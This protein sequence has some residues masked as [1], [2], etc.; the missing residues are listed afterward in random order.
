[1]SDCNPHLISKEYRNWIGPVRAAEYDEM[2]QRWEAN[3]QSNHLIREGLRVTFTTE[4]HWPLSGCAKVGTRGTIGYL[5]ERSCRVL[6]LWSGRKFYGLPLEKEGAVL[7]GFL[8][9]AS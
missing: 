5:Q 4:Q 8:R 1:M 7:P 3:R 2:A 9:L 6:G